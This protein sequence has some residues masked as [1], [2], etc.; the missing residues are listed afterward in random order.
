MVGGTRIRVA[1]ILGCY[2]QGMNIE[3][4]VQQYPGLKPAD[5]HNALAYPYDHL[6]EIEA[7]LTSEDDATVKALVSR[8]INPE[9][10]SKL[11]SK[12]TN[13]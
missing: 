2:R 10:S 11:N 7:D 5:I 1:I 9:A 3:K 8:W 12:G 4:I 13:R 6:D